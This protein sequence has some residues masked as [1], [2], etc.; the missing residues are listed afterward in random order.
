[1]YEHLLFAGFF[2]AG[3]LFCLGGGDSLGDRLLLGSDSTLA[4]QNLFHDLLFLNQKGAD[5]AAA[6]AAGTARATIGTGNAL[7]TLGE[8]A[9]LTGTQGRNTVQLDT[10][11]TTLG[12]TGTLVDVQVGELAT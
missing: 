1:M 12:H 4:L 11:V 2:A 9:V 8:L 7:A 3:G 6:H 10:A 5:D